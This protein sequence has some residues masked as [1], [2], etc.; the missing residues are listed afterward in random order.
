M[1]NRTQKRKQS[2]KET[3]IYI[4]TTTNKQTNKQTLRTNEDK[5]ALRRLIILWCIDG[6]SGSG[7]GRRTRR[8]S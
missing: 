2:G 4:H 5:I 8:A 3:E 6:G 7:G 1:T